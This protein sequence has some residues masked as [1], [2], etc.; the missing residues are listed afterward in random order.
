MITNKRK[1]QLVID[2]TKTSESE[3]M[4]QIVR[5]LDE[6]GIQNLNLVGEGRAP[7]CR[8]RGERAT[9]VA[10]DN[11]GLESAAVTIDRV[12]RCSGLDTKT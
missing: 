10:D 9:L 11:S 5:F 2:A 7:S 1:P 8:D 3:A 6:Q 4:A 12:C